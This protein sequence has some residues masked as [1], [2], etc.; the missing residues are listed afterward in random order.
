MNEREIPE[1]VRR[2]IAT[3]ID[4]VSQLEA[5]LLLRNHR[6]Q[7]WTAEEAGRRLYVS[8]TVAAYILAALSERGFFVEEAQGY[9]FDPRTPETDQAVAELAA[10]YSRDLIGVTHLVHAKP[11]P[12]VLEFAKAFRLRRED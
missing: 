4:S 5:I 10:A 2:L 9:R 11:T 1:V 12:G 7:S 8:Q 3:S 6:G